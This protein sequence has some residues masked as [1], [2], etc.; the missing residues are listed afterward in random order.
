MFRFFPNAK[1]SLES[2]LNLITGLVEDGLLF[3]RPMFRSRAALSAEVLFL[4]T[5]LAFYPERQVQP[6]RLND[7]ARFSFILCS[8]FCNWKDHFVI[9]KPDTLSGWHRKAFQAQTRS[10]RHPNVRGH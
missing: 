9:V 10:T 6:R 2:L 3:F 4:R 1:R 5:L 8:R 7:S